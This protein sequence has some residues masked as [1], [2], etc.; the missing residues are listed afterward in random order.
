MATFGL[1][2]SYFPKV[3]GKYVVYFRASLRPH[4]NLDRE[5]QR[6]A[7]EVL[8]AKGWTR[9]VGDFEEIEPLTLGARPK[10]DQAIA[11]CKDHNATLIFG[12]FGQMRGGRRWLEEVF[13]H[14][15]KVRAADLPNWTYAEFSRFII[16]D[17]HRC[18]DA[19]K[20]VRA[21]LAIAKSQGVVLGGARPN[22]W[23]LEIGPA[24][25]ASSRSATARRRDQ[26]TMREIRS[27]QKE[28]LS[29]LTDI[30]LRLNE[31]GLKAPRGGSWSPAQV[32]R[33]IQRSEETRI[34]QSTVP[35]TD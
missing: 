9:L 13:R 23:G 10:L 1:D 34:A 32:L 4:S 33:V 25:S 31:M 3:R 28:G 27:I 30:A 12:K 15:I 7:V 22:S 11:C 24:K 35:C 8:L 2:P 29:S 16:E 14:R 20:K 5:R 18:T 21:A 17:K 19:G 26:F 6:Q